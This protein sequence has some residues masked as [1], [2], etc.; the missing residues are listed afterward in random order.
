M[1]RDME[2]S[3]EAQW[4]RVRAK[5]RAE[6]GDAAFKS[7]F[8]PL[9][10]MSVENGEV[11]IAVSTRFIR[12]WVR[13]HYGDR[14]RTLWQA[15]N[16]GVRAIDFTIQGGDGPV[17]ERADTPPLPGHRNVS[18]PMTNGGRPPSGPPPAPIISMNERDEFGAPSTSASR[19]RT[20]SP[21]SRTNSRPPRR[22]AWPTRPRCRSTRSSSMAGS[23]SA[24]R[25]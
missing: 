22:G 25:I 2:A 4:A 21:A 15:E 7:W 3:V 6:Y 13:N 24:R 14:L 11:R 20:G 5:L 18:K 17:R 16:K 10:L 1:R 19:S 8:K 9:T 12:D 23:G